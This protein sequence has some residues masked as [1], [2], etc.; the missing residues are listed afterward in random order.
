MAQFD[1]DYIGSKKCQVIREIK[2]MEDFFDDMLE[3]GFCTEKDK[4]D[5]KKKLYAMLNKINKIIEE[6]Y[7]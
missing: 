6:D 5:T 2:E 4:T 3:A 1:A 7:E